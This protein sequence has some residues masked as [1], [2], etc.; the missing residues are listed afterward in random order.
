ML[1]HGVGA[2]GPF[3]PF[4]ETKLIQGIDAYY[5]YTYWWRLTSHT[6]PC[7][8]FCRVWCYRFPFSS[9]IYLGFGGLLF[10]AVGS[11]SAALPLSC[12]RISRAVV[13]CGKQLR[14]RAPQPMKSCSMRPRSSIVSTAPFPATVLRLGQPLPTV[15]AR[16][17]NKGAQRVRARSHPHPHRVLAVNAA[18]HPCSSN[19]PRPPRRSSC[20]RSTAW[21]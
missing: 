7:F 11:S 12:R 16:H 13:C 8:F 10:G 17:V 1:L 4:Q 14:G 9:Y 20:C 18:C 6:M 21:R 5:I 2:R 3:L 19:P 15:T